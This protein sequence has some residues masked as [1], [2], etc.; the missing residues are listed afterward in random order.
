MG[1]VKN[2]SLSKSIGTGNFLPSSVPSSRACPGIFVLSALLTRGMYMVLPLEGRYPVHT[3]YVQHEVRRIPGTYPVRAATC[4]HS[5]FFSIRKSRTVAQVWA[6]M[7][8]VCFFPTHLRRESCS[9]AFQWRRCA[10]FFRTCAIG[11]HTCAIGLPTCATMRSR[12]RPGMRMSGP[13]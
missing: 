10:H 11:R 13:G 3:R 4:P 7:A 1:C 8:Q 2:L 12:V 6:C 9:R 5:G